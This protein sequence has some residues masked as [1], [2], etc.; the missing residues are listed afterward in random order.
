[1]VRAESRTRPLPGAIRLRERQAALTRQ[2]ILTAARELFAERGYAGT[3]VRLLARRAG[4]APQTIYA[5]FG[6]KAGVLAALP[7]LIDREAGVDELYERRHALT[8]PVELLGLLARINRRVRERCGDVVDILRAGAAGEPEVAAVL[9]ESVRRHRR[10]VR[11]VLARVE[12]LGALAPGVTLSH[13][14]DVTLALMS[15]EMCDTL[16][17]QARWSYARYERWLRETLVTLLLKD[18]S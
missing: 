10:G 9:E 3:P 5:T 18:D 7:A 1:M 16:V 12:E 14:A 6:S 15:H 8:D 4:V 2:A 13:A 11:D 17:R